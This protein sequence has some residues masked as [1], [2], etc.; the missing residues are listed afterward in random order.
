[1]PR[2]EFTNAAKTDIAAFH[3][4]VHKGRITPKQLEAYIKQVTEALGGF[5]ARF[6]DVS[7]ITNNPVH[8]FTGLSSGR[9]GD[10][11]PKQALIFIFERRGKDYRIFS[12]SEK[13][14]SPSYSRTRVI[15]EAKHIEQAMPDIDSS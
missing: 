1:M 9:P 5:E 14:L 11:F 8:S 7:Y 4:R 10:R 15:E 2:I 6:K 12:T 13:T 3:A